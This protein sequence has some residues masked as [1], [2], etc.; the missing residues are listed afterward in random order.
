MATLL[1]APGIQILISTARHGIVDVSDDIISGSL[2]RS[3]DQMAS[4]SFVLNNER[5]KYD[6]VFTPNDR[7]V[8]QMKR[9]AWVQVFAGYLNSVPYRSIFPRKV[10]ITASCT[11][12]RLMYRYWDPGSEAAV[13]L[14]DTR[15]NGQGFASSTDGGI[16]DRVMRLLTEV[17]EWPAEAIH[18]GGLPSR[19]FDT[20]A[21]LQT[22]LADR[23]IV[24]VDS[25]GGDPT[26]G[27]N[28]LTSLGT[29]TAV[30]G[31]AFTGVLPDTAGKAS[32]FGGP[33]GGAFGRMQLTGELGVSPS[34]PWY[35]A[36]R[37]P[38][39]GYVN[40][41]INRFGSPDQYANAVSWWRNR[42][43]L[44]VNPTTNKAVVLRA[45]DWGPGGNVVANDRVI[46]M[47]KTALDA[48]GAT[49]DS[50]V[51]IRF[52]GDGL[53]LGQ[54]TGKGLILRKADPL[55]EDHPITAQPST[56]QGPTG[57]RFTSADG[58]Q[59]H[60]A[61]AREWIRSAWAE[62][63]PGKNSIGGYSYRY[64]AGTNTLSDHSFGLALDVGVGAS[65]ISGRTA[66]QLA[67]G[68]SVAAWFIQNPNVFGTKYVI[69][70]NHI[71]YGDGRGWLLYSSGRY[72]N[73]LSLGHFNH[74][75][76]SF[77]S[78]AQGAP[79]ALG[80]MGGAWV[81]SNMPGFPD[82]STS[83]PSGGTSG[84]LINSYLWTNRTTTA[85]QILGGIR[86]LMNDQPLFGSVQS[87]TNASMRS[88][89]SAPN[90]DFIAWFP[91]Y[92]GVYKTAGRMVVKDIEL[93]GDGFTLTWD[94]SRLKTHMFVTGSW[95]GFNDTGGIGGAVDLFMQ[96][97]TAGIAS[98][99]YPEIM[100][101]LFNVSPDEVGNVDFSDPDVILQRFGARPEVLNA[102]EISGAQAE[103]WLALH[104]F[105]KNWAQQF[106]A[107]IELTFM[108]EVFPGMLL[109]LETY[110][111]QVYV[112]AVN[113]TFDFESGFMTRV[114][115][116]APSAT[117]GSGLVGLPRGEVS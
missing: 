5:R 44:V 14:L 15:G 45:A 46:D 18:I 28:S 79:T 27:G 2:D 26:V 77:K 101:A 78:V 47:S 71:N 25:L 68:T 34:D 57:I 75:H 104:H 8:V 103:F 62:S 86:A 54:I 94:D 85:G 48:L 42:K 81:G 67:H 102:G 6:G 106:S 52:A 24:D 108:P 64:I 9:I 38:Y 100:Q 41:K 35:C 76:I 82:Y 30:G 90:G 80:P 88:F 20:V 22:K 3:E 29:T 23:V 112:T 99:E 97:Q 37:W 12:K 117:D 11:L 53:P 84:N 95:D 1:Y 73:D 19:W 87:L 51:Q 16:R 61:A 91:D 113:H 109:Y 39:Q 65:S 114:T 40:G 60:V 49:T 56:M 31:G 63:A 70:N 66:A 21:S 83:G 92:F 58:L 74:V 93:A 98:V 17:G 36:M 116:I 33:N 13:A 111:L 4:L 10:P 69:W 115:V 72:S 110:G 32:W 107:Q 89:S 7:I 59:P 50:Y 96:F 43:I 55:G 105:Q